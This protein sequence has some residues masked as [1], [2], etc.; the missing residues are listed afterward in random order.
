MSDSSDEEAAAMALAMGFSSFGA[1]PSKKKRKFNSATDAFVD[2]QEQLTP[3]QLE[4]LDRGGKKGKG[5]GGNNVALGR[6]RVFGTGSGSG[7]VSYEAQ[8]PLVLQ[9]HSHAR[10]DAEI[11]L[12]GGGADD[13]SG[14]EERPN[15]MDTSLPAPVEELRGI[16][17]GGE[18]SLELQNQA[19][20]K[21]TEAA[22]EMQAKIDSILASAQP[23]ISVPPPPA[24][25]LGYTDSA[26]TEGRIRSPPAAAVE[27]IAGSSRGGGG[28]GMRGG[29]G[30]GSARGGRRNERWWEG[31]YDPSFNVNPWEALEKKMELR[32]VGSWLE[33]GHWDL[34]AGVRVPTTTSAT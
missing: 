3:E 27:S 25:P 32:S 6:A 21:A 13:E 11:N 31:Y 33:K 30:G 5:S 29:R 10:N 26:S 20:E 16:G 23:G 17:S 4:N 22:D 34:N 18:G 7:G 9:A 15:Y 28:D 8:A 24:L 19:T 1:P 12:Y 2:G 14:D